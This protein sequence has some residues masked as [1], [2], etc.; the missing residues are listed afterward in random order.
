MSPFNPFKSPDKNV[1]AGSLPERIAK[2][3]FWGGAKLAGKAVQKTAE[4]TARAAGQDGLADSISGI[5]T[6][7]EAKLSRFQ[8]EVLSILSVETVANNMVQRTFLQPVDV[9]SVSD[10]RD[11]NSP[12]NRL[13]VIW[14]QLLEVEI[15]EVLPGNVYDAY[16]IATFVE[17]DGRTRFQLKAK[18]EVK[19]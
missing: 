12:L 6:G 4:V 9:A 10:M 13:R 16:R 11:R 3:I 15:K 2:G 17:A 5:G 1:I 7:R 8:Q 18:T 14:G 19:K